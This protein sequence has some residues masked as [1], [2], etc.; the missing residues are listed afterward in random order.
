MLP[1]TEDEII[2]YGITEAATSRIIEVRQRIA[3]LTST[4]NS[5]HILEK[6]IN[7]EGVSVD[8]HTLYTDLLEWRSLRYELG[9]LT[10]FL[11]KI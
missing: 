4:Y 5:Q 2:Q 7:E 1:L 10:G 9:Q 8:D 3:Q 11:E 6:R